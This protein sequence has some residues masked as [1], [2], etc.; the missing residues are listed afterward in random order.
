MKPVQT[1]REMGKKQNGTL[2]VHWFIPGTDDL[3]MVRVEV[4][5]YRGKKCD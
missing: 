2:I 3:R 1:K 4:R 5:E